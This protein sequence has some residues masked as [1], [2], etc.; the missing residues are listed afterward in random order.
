MIG[1]PRR[2][3]ENVLPQF[4]FGD[5][6]TGQRLCAV[7]CPGLR[8]ERIVAEELKEVAVKF[9]GAGLDRRVDCRSGDVAE[10]G[11]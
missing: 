2:A 7:V 5:L 10:L 11:G 6:R 9:V 1:P 8:V 4:R 3:A